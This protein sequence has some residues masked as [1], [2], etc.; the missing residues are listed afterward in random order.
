MNLKYNWFLIILSFTC[1]LIVI[2]Y[3]VKQWE[4]RKCIFSSLAY[5]SKDIKHCWTLHNGIINISMMNNKHKFIFICNLECIVW[6][7]TWTYLDIHHQIFHLQYPV[8]PQFESDDLRLLVN[9]IEQAR[10]FLSQSRSFRKLF[11]ATTKPHDK[12]K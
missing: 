4:L 3:F 8:L 9:E 5:L 6:A 10:H 1:F 11:A 12:S 2:L 7:F